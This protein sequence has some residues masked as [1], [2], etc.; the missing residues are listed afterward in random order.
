[1]DYHSELQRVDDPRSRLDRNRMLNY[2][3]GQLSIDDR[4]L[5][6]LHELHGWTVP[7]LARLRKRPEGTIKTRIRR[8]KLKM[9]LVLATT[10]NKP[11]ELA[12][13]RETVYAMSTGKKTLD[14]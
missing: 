9:R 5:I 7:E 13:P 1:M 3:L 12:A 6:I 8:A 2:L 10:K 14:R 4:A 11:T